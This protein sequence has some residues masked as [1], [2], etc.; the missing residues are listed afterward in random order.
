M[1][2]NSKEAELW[3]E[4]MRLKSAL[5]ASTELLVTVLHPTG[6]KEYEADIENQ[7]VINREL[8]PR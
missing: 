6:E 3:S 4:T 5:E 1:D 2:V 7:I 8:L